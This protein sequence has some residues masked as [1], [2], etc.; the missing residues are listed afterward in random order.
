MTESKHLKARIR[1]RMARTGERYMTARRHV[2]GARVTAPDD[3]HGWRLRGGVHPDTAAIA[4]VLH[5][6]GA[7]VSE[8][9]VLGAGGGL[10][11]G[12]ILW[13]FE[14]RHHTRT[15]VLGF[16]NQWQYPG[17]W[18]E[19]TLER[20]GVPFELH[21]T[22]GARGAAGKLDAALAAGRPVL[23]TIDRQTLGHWHL[24]A[25]LE[26]RGGYPVVVYGAVGDRMRIDDRNLA[27]L[28]V[29][30][31]RLDA[32][33]ARVG[34]YK[35]RLVIPEPAAVGEERLREAA[36]A[37][38]ADAV[39]HLSARS[40]SFGLPA[41]RKWARMLVDTDNA[42]AWP[43]V[44]EDPTGLV[45]ALLSSYEG[46]EPVGADG[47]HLRALYADFLDEAASLLEEPALGVAAGAY[48][49]LAQHW[50]ELAELALPPALPP[51][52]MLREQLA[53]VHES[54]IARGD[55][56]AEDARRAAAQLWELRAALDSE[57]PFD[58]DTALELFVRL[59]EQLEVIYA[60]EVEALSRLRSGRRS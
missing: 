38:L 40:D 48:R 15:L 42:K 2:V 44:F 19:K 29:P 3:D 54:V 32:A 28:T 25:D 23:A 27:P 35:H 59:G 21:E 37:G 24:P 55:A 31:E 10:G 22:G 50:H 11:A 39:A 58:H 52:A 16:R 47:G 18:A 14:A 53:A 1:E 33:R 45:G 17:R 34:S 56:G 41:W 57:P 51:F 13:E 60:A 5:H 49:E 30:R 6:H 12:Y 4:N 20:L 26:G 7:E 36:R 9:M 46:V 8:A 43:R